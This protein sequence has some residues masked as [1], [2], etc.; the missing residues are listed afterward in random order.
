MLIAILCFRPMET[1]ETR[2]ETLAAGDADNLVL[3]R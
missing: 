1:V 3:D 2:L